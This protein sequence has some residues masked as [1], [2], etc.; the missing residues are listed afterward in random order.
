MQDP[1]Y[2]NDNN[3]L[4]PPTNDLN[5]S[6]SNNNYE[7]MI[8][9][10]NNL[11]NELDK[12]YN[13]TN[14]PD[15]YLCFLIISFI[16]WFCLL[17]SAW[18]TFVLP[19]TDIDDIFR[20][21]LHYTL[22][23]STSNCAINIQYYIFCIT[24]IFIYVIVTIAFF[25]IIYSGFIK[26]N[27]NVLIGLLGTTTRFH[28]LPLIFITGNFVLGEVIDIDKEPEDVHFIISIALTILA[29]ISLIFIS[30]QTKI[31]LNFTIEMAIIKAAYSSFIAF[32]TYYLIYIIWFYKV[33]KEKYDDLD[34]WH[35]KCANI[36]SIALGVLNIFFS[37]L[38]KEPI[39][40]LINCLICSGKATY[41]FSISK[42]YREDI[43]DNNAPGIIDIA[44]SIASA[45][46]MILLYMNLISMK[47]RPQIS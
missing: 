11:N 38:L 27:N 22:R 4:L 18:L 15:N 21:W 17:V 19:D 9:V 33:H 2:Y 14:L 37:I 1:S 25:T 30:F 6:Q 36:G 45:L 35:K 26:R 3:G 5:N 44:M 28:F 12:M 13:D 34:S 20:V 10:N 39:I 24:I 23:Y 32:L 8:P 46:V 47:N 43:Y 29:L 42:Y 40:L 31:Q 7:Q 41:F 16:A